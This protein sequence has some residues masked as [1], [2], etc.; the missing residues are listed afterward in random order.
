MVRR[1]RDR[2]SRRLLLCNRERLADEIIFRKALQILF[3]RRHRLVILLCVDESRD[4]SPL[5][6]S[7]VRIQRHSRARGRY[8]GILHPEFCL[9]GGQVN[10]SFRQPLIQAVSTMKQ[11]L[12][13]F[14]EDDFIRKALAIAEQ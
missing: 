3:H 4:K 13:R 2:Y 12:E 7:R 5:Q 9:H 10:P 8:R 14:P 6:W 1:L 11:Y